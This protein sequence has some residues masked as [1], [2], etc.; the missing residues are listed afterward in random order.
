M[1]ELFLRIL[2]A[3]FGS[4]QPVDAGAY[5]TARASTHT[6]P[7]DWRNSVVDLLKVLDMDSSLAGRQDLADE[8][9]YGGPFDG[10]AQMNTWLHAEVMK[11]VKSGKYR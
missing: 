4:R 6:E 5:L 7:L 10:S 11:R 1:G 2:R 9:G 8:L 3:I